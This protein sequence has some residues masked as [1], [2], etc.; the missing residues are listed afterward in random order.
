MSAITR[1]L[2]EIGKRGGEARA[3]AMTKKQRTEAARAAASA[4]RKPDAPRCPC[5]EMTAKRAKAR[6]HKC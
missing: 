1:Y 2:A 4:P 6:G 3:A 5:G